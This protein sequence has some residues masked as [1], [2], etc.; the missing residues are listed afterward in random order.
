MIKFIIKV[1]MMVIVVGLI[2]MLVVVL[3]EF[4]VLLDGFIWF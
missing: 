2:E 1:A 4:E 3:V